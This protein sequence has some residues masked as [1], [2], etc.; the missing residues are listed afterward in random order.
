[1][2]RKERP[3]YRKDPF[4]KSLRY[5][6]EFEA[7]IRTY[8]FNL[9]PMQQITDLRFHPQVTYVCGENASGKSTLL[10]S[11]AVAAGFSEDGGS[12]WMHSTGENASLEH[13][14]GEHLIPV[15]GLDRP[16]WGFFLRAE[17][18]FETAKRLRTAGV[19][20]SYG[21]T[22]FECSHGES[23]MGLIAYRAQA[24]SLYI[25]DEPE[26]ALSPMRQLELLAHVDRLCRLGGQFII[27]THSPIIMAYPNCRFYWVD[28]KGIKEQ[29]W[30]DTPHYHTWKDFF[31]G[32]DRVVQQLF[33]AYD[34]P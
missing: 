27:A 9:K 24:R 17:T 32:P 4:I 14:T 30:Q 3:A 8:P 33:A 34:K 18:Y 22:L 5:E 13:G 20:G 29:N 28:G 11:I 31:Q 25:L 26:S 15:R 19:E 1:M 21:G 10:E 16:K 7:D 6:R 23:F 12:I 2:A